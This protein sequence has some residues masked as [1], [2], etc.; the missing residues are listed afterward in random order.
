MRKNRDTARR[1]RAVEVYD[2]EAVFCVSAVPAEDDGVPVPGDDRREDIGVG[3]GDDSAEPS[4][5]ETSREQ[6]VEARGVQDPEPVP[7][8]TRAAPNGAAKGSNGCPLGLVEI[9]RPP[10]TSATGLTRMAPGKQG[11][12]P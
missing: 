12:K 1:S 2:V 11:W 3:E 10:D 7:T 6:L 4:F 5:I 9:R 8:G